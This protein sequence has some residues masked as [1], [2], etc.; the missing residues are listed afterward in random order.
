MSIEGPRPGRIT[1]L[2]APPAPLT[3]VRVSR[4]RTV[5]TKRKRGDLTDP[6]ITVTPP[7]PEPPPAADF[8]TPAPVAEEAPA[9][10]VAFEPLLRADP[11]P[12]IEAE[13]SPA[14]FPP[15]GLVAEA[16]PLSEPFFPEPSFSE[17]SFSESIF[18]EPSEPSF[19]ES[20]FSEPSFSKSSFSE[21]SEP[22]FS[23][24]SFS[25]PS[26]PSFS[27]PSFPESSFSEASFSEA[28]F[29]EPSF[30]DPP[31]PE[32]SFSAPP[33]PSPSYARPVSESVPEPPV[34]ALRSV[35]DLIDYW[36]ELRNG[37]AV[38]SLDEVDRALVAGCWSNSL[39][40]AF[41]ETEPMLPRITRLGQTDGEIEFAPMVIDWMMSR[42]RQCA[43]RGSPMEEEQRFPLTKGSA[44]YK[45]L[46]L[47]LSSFGINSDCVLCLV[48]RAQELSV[49]AAFK[50][51]LAS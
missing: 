6:L 14:K 7:V 36:D 32:P 50:R 33:F 19:S 35:D 31:F 5:E 38:P 24:S 41:G 46:L 49:T 43:R 1:G 29:S 8:P 28:S 39:I 44:R 45:L 47:P 4:R 20:S 22:S 10:A 9:L 18:S 48:T 16:S 15:P 27:E 23:E 26:E 11:E 2:E 21:P 34:Y 12:L 40:L 3:L 17:S 42:G 51:W 13:P 30:S 37:R 25:G